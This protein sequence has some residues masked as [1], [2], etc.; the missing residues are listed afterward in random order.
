MGA[1]TGYLRPG[2]AEMPL[3]NHSLRLA[4]PQVCHGWPGTVVVF[5]LRADAAREI[6]TGQEN[7][8]VS[9]TGVFLLSG[10]LIVKDN[11]LKSF[12]CLA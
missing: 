7:T 4:P 12:L 9:G 11:A 5:L 2:E 3:E 1:D 10:N 6:Q 8:S